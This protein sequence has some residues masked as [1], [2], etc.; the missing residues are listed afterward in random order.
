MLRYDLQQIF[1]FI[2]SDSKVLD[3]GCGDGSLL[4]QLIDKKNCV[5]YG[6][7]IDT[8]KII[9]SMKKNINVIQDDLEKGLSIFENDSFDYVVLSQTIQSMSKV[10]IILI[11]MIRV[12]K[13]IIVTFPNFGFWKN[14]LQICFKGHM[15]KS[16]NMPYDWY[17]TPNIHWCTLKDFDELCNK[18]NI[19]IKNKLV[20]TNSK[21]VRILHNLLGSLALY[22]LSRK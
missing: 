17:N 4:K 1:N 11:E 16:E 6:V 12:A 22:K 13:N 18:N 3:L 20:I 8:V 7:E 15:P 2:P 5:G 19:V 9:D 14:R 10:E 21:K